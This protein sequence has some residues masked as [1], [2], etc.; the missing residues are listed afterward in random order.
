MDLPDVLGLPVE[1]A[2]ARLSQAGWTQVEE[3][4]TEPPRRPLTRGE[5]RVVRLR[6][7]EDR[8][9][10]VKA[11]FLPNVETLEPETACD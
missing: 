11:L 9:V 10:L 8:V 2:R 1:Q 7:Q 4:V 3:V 5:W 6:A